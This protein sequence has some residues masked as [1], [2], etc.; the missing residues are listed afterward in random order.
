MLYMPPK[1]LERD[2]QQ[3]IKIVNSLK[4]NQAGLWLREISRRTELHPDRVKTL[5]ERYPVLFMDHVN[6]RSYD[7]NLKIIKLSKPEISKEA[8]ARYLKFKHKIPET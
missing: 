6:F 1:N 2:L 3:I 7:I 5:I 8:I 4:E